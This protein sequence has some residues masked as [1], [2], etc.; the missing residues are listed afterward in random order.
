RRIVAGDVRGALPDAEKLVDDERAATHALKYVAI[1]AHFAG[2]ATKARAAA[3]RLQSLAA[4]GDGAAAEAWLTVLLATG[5]ADRAVAAAKELIARQPRSVAGWIVVQDAVFT[6]GR[7]AEFADLA[8]RAL[9][10]LGRTMPQQSAAMARHLA[11]LVAKA[12]PARAA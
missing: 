5:H 1:A 6:L 2:D 10:V 4:T 3:D 9:R 7:T 8:P 12:E 11:E